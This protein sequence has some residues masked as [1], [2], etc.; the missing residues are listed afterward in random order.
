M[1]A[2]MARLPLPEPDDAH[3]LDWYPEPDDNPKGVPVE[4]VN[5]WVEETLTRR[6]DVVNLGQ[7]VA[8]EAGSNRGGHLGVIQMQPERTTLPAFDL[9]AAARSVAESFNLP[10][11]TLSSV[12]RGLAHQASVLRALAD[13]LERAE[14][15]T[16]DEAH[17]LIWRLE[18][19]GTPLLTAVRMLESATPPDPHR[20][21]MKRIVAQVEA[22]RHRG[23]GAPPRVYFMQCMK[24]RLVKIG[25]SLDWRT[26]RREIA[27][28]TGHDLVALGTREGDAWDEKIIHER[29]WGNRD[30]GEWFHMSD[31]LRDYI[32][33][34]T[35]RPDAVDRGG[36]SAP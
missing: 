3:P 32:R 30:H 5:Q 13:D 14:S 31:A 36:W 16:T 4:I 23:K 25:T 24:C 1:V 21:A 22:R 28:A 7:Q 15:L 11:P 6:E 35:T 10:P 9:S 8:P 2:E 33:D 29:F 20:V 26:R 19:A 34:K 27:R 18:S 12:A 17:A